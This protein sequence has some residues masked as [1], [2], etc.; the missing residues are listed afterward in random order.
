MRYLLLIMVLLVYLTVQNNA[1][2]T[3]TYT[4]KYD[5]IDLD[6]VISNDRLLTGYIKCLLE[7]GPCTAD[8]KELKENLPD[9][10]ENNCKRCSQRQREGANKVM[11]YIIDH[12][13]DD[14]V[15]LEKKYDPE[16]NYKTKYL[17]SKESEGKQADAAKSEE[18]A[19]NASRE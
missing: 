12:R 16:G 14:W 18:D 13:P 15:T 19:K 10:I 5:G 8:G 4:T 17:A 6:E 7:E 2:E 11:H 9:A 1:I 3:S